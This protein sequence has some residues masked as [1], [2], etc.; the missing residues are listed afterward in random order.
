MP[1]PGLAVNK[2]VHKG[3][4]LALSWPSQLPSDQA[5]LPSLSP[6]GVQTGL[7]ARGSGDQSANRWQCGS[8]VCT[9][10]RASVPASEQWVFDTKE[11][12]F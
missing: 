11:S 4:A 5:D 12:D 8:A 9:Q 2:Q 1:P 3:H 6:Q 7:Q 10:A